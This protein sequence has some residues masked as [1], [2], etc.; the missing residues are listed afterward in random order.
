MSPSCWPSACAIDSSRGDESGAYKA[1]MSAG[2]EACSDRSSKVV[3]ACKEY[4]PSLSYGFHDPRLQLH[5]GDGFQYLE[6]SNEKF[7]VIITDSSDPEVA[8][9]DESKD[10]E[11]L[12]YGDLSFHEHF[13]GSLYAV[14]Q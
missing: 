10:G 14:G 3:N 1:L 13:K 8:D 4:I 7:D 12:R 5:F 9:G 2:G 11:Q 6:S